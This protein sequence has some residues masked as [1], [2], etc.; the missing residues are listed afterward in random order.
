M[1]KDR[2]RILLNYRKF[3]KILKHRPYRLGPVDR[4]KFV[5]RLSRCSKRVTAA[6]M[7]WLDFGSATTL[8]YRGV[9]FRNLVE[10]KHL[11]PLEAFIELE[12]IRRGGSHR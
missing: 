12:R 8:R 1:N 2:Y 10:E 3:S 11:T 5:W 7:D 6:A 4:L 9:S